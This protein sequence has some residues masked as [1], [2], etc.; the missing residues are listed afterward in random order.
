MRNLSVITAVEESDGR[1]SSVV[2]RPIEIVSNPRHN[3]RIS[4]WTTEEFRPSDSSTAVITL[5]LLM[6]SLMIDFRGYTCPSKR[7]KRGKEKSEKRKR[8]NTK[9]RSAHGGIRTCDLLLVKPALLTTV[10]LLMC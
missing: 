6:I 3:P 2:Q 7:G 5:R 10:L 1:N 8:N 4:L 9:E